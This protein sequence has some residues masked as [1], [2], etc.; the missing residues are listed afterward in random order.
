MLSKP[1]IP[2]FLPL[3]SHSCKT[4]A[5]QVPKLIVCLR[6]PLFLN[7]LL[8]VCWFCILKGVVKKRFG[9]FYSFHYKYYMHLLYFISL[10]YVEIAKYE[11]NKCKSHFSLDD[12]M[13]HLS[14]F[15]TDYFS[16]RQ[17]FSTTAGSLGKLCLIF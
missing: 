12:H 17:L 7:K 10:K 11:S 3:Y 14:D 6:F 16:H 13:M 5:K 8:C 2:F 1:Q 15:I 9:M 4:A